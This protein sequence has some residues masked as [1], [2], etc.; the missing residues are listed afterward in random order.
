MRPKT[1]KR[2]WDEEEDRVL[3]EKIAELGPRQWELVAGAITGR[4]G[5]QCRERWNN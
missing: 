5:K 2:N 1:V 3:V 4:L